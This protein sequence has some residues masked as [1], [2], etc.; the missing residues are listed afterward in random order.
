MVRVLVP[1]ILLIALLYPASAA[2]GQPLLNPPDQRTQSEH[3]RQ[4]VSH[5]G[6]AFFELTPRHQDADAARAFDEAIACFER[7]VRERPASAVA[8]AY[9]ARIHAIRGNHHQAARHYD[10]VSDLEPANVDAC[11]LAALALGRLGDWEGARQ[12]LLAARSRTSDPEV[13]ARL[14]DYLAR[15]ERHARLAAGGVR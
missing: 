2:T 4:G 14:A 10:R 15:A 5:F 7:E 8:H 9:L 1:L 12:R 13:L 11:V 6:R 3:I